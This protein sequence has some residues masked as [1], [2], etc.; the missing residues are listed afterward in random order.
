MRREQDAERVAPAVPLPVAQRFLGSRQQGLPA[1]LARL[2]RVVVPRCG[3][4]ELVLVPVDAVPVERGELALAQA[5]ANRQNEHDALFE[6][7]TLERKQQLDL[8]GVEVLDRVAALRARREA[9]RQLR[10]LA[11]VGQAQSLTH[12]GFEAAVEQPERVARSLLADRPVGLDSHALAGVELGA[13]RAAFRQRREP[14]VQHRRRDDVERVVGERSASNVRRAEHVVAP[15]V[16]PRACV[17][18]LRVA[19]HP[20]LAERAQRRRARHLGTGQQRDVALLLGLV[21]RREVADGG[22]A[23]LAVRNADAVPAALEGDG[24]LPVAHR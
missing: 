22:R 9:A 1:A 2:G 23:T 16:D 15:S 13:K 12:G 4:Q 19:R 21:D 17:L 8:V 10:A 18:L 20:S 7:Q 6:R 3:D 5:L 24:P 14:C 11:R